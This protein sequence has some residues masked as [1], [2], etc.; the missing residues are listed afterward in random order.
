VT[1][2][3]PKVFSGLPIG[4]Q[5]GKP[6]HLQYLKVETFEEQMRWEKIAWKRAVVNTSET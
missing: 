4:E 5:T 3:K 6:L 1:S 2:G